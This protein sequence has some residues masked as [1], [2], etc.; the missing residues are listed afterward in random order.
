MLFFP[1]FHFEQF[2]MFL[3]YP[4]PLLKN[5]DLKILHCGRE[6]KLK[7]NFEHNRENTIGNKTYI[8]TLL[9][10]KK[11]KLLITT[12]FNFAWSDMSPLYVRFKLK[13]VML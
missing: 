6:T 2:N 4:P 8:G 7:V 1:V 12:V 9:L 13:N 10:R 3:I 11:K 5:W